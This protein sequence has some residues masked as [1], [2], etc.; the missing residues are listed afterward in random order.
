[1]GELTLAYE[2]GELVSYAALD[3]SRIEA[4]TPYL[5]SCSNTY[6]LGAFYGWL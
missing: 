5:I 6:V 1:M 4:Q 2:R 3:A